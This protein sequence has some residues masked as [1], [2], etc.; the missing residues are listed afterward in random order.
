MEIDN[1]VPPRTRLFELKS[2]AEF[3]AED[4]QHTIKTWINMASLLVKQGNMAESKGDD[5]NAYISYVRACLIITKIIPLQP[6]YPTMMNDIACIDLRQK[7]LVIITRMGHLERRLLKRFEEDN[8]KVAEQIKRESDLAHF[9]S[10]LDKPGPLSANHQNLFCPRTGSI[11]I[12]NEQAMNKL[13]L[14]YDPIETYEQDNIEEDGDQDFVNDGDDSNTDDSNNSVDRGVFSVEIREG[15]LEDGSD[16]ILELSPESYI[17]HHHRRVMTGPR[18]VSPMQQLYQEQHQKQLDDNQD[19]DYNVAE[20][21]HYPSGTLKKKSSNEDERDLLSPEC[22]PNYTTMPSALF[23]RQREGFHVRRCSST[24]T[25]RTSMHFPSSSLSA[26]TALPLNTASRSSL[27]TPPIP[28]RSNKRNSMIAS[29]SVDRGGIN[30][31]NN[32]I[33]YLRDRSSYNNSIVPDYRGTAAAGAGN[34]VSGS[35]TIARI[36]YERDVLHSRFSSRRTMSFEGNS[37]FYPSLE[38]PLD[39]QQNLGG[40]SSLWRHNST[41]AGRMTPNNVNSSVGYARNYSKRSSIYQQQQQEEQELYQ[42]QQNLQSHTSYNNSNGNVTAST[43]LNLNA[44]LPPTPRSSLEKLSEH[45]SSGS[46]TNT[47]THNNGS[48]CN[49]PSPPSSSSPSTGFST[50]FTS[51]MMKSS[52]QMA[53]VGCGFGQ[54][55]GHTPSLTSS[56]TSGT[57]FAMTESTLA[58]S[59]NVTATNSSVTCTPTTMSVGSPQPSSSSSSSSPTMAS[60]S[61]WTTSASKKNG[62][63]RK[64][65]SKPKMQ[66][67]FDMIHAPSS[68]SPSPSPLPIHRQQ[69]YQYQQQHQNQHQQQYSSLA[70]RS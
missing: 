37:I 24:D 39:V 13:N 35:V 36:G 28:I 32:G 64:I 54:G 50:P 62:L 45:F 60:F 9:N 5:E 2:S 8:L 16:L 10:K 51:P 12:D 41:T 6:H 3:A 29:V 31:S 17:N 68:P 46:A 56:I 42:R 61:A 23:P 59:T 19:S 4:F 22:Q 55:H 25:I 40:A 67:M 43:T 69:Q 30:I 57:T 27:T 34:L 52:S 21:L 20:K 65:R 7:I 33:N 49:Q 58:M 66:E 15:F 38:A 1:I 70:M 63:L 47:S 14:D 44:D 11:V 48:N 53:Q 18:S 26:V